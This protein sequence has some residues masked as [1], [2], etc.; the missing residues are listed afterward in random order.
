M[1]LTACFTGVSYFD[2]YFKIPILLPKDI[3]NF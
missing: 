1:R 2:V 3:D